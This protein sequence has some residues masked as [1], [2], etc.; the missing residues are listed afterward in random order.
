MSYK[1]MTPEQLDDLV[2]EMEFKR[3]CIKDDETMRQAEEEGI[4]D[5]ENSGGD[6]KR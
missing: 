6:R 4:F 5:I 3:E 2:A 1:E